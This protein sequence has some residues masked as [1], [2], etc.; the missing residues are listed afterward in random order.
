MRRPAAADQSGS[1]EAFRLSIRHLHPAPPPAA[2]PARVNEPAFAWVAVLRRWRS[3]PAAATEFGGRVRHGPFHDGRSTC[4]ERHGFADA[5]LARGNGRERPRSQLHRRNQWQ[6]RGIGRLRAP[7]GQPRNHHMRLMPFSK[8][9]VVYFH[10]FRF[11]LKPFYCVTC[12]PLFRSHWSNSPAVESIAD[13]STNFLWCTFFSL[14][15]QLCWQLRN[16]T[17][18]ER[19]GAP[20]FCVASVVVFGGLCV[21]ACYNVHILSQLFQAATMMISCRVRGRPWQHWGKQ[22]LA[23]NLL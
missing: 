16:G 13:Q 2:L 9:V 10:K 18:N 22:T 12:C 14:L 4:Q 6:F 19:S 8:I 7:L 11:F 5:R 21:D 1:T 3:L 15:L 17:R 20:Y 23:N